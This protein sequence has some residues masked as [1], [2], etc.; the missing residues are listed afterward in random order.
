MN[1]RAFLMNA[2]DEVSLSL[3]QAWLIDR[4]MPIR[5]AVGT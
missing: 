5:I 2:V 3:R 4:K 1:E